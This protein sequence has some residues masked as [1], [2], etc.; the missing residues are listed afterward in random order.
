MVKEATPAS[1]I[2]TALLQSSSRQHLPLPLLLIINMFSRS[3]FAV[4]VVAAA[5]CRE[6]TVARTDPV[7]DLTDSRR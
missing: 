4:V 7:L 2:P 6:S 1:T 3:I 5:C